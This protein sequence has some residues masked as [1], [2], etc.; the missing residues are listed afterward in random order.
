MRLLLLSV[1]SLA[2]LSAAQAPL[3]PQT[4]TFNSNFALTAAQIS[5]AGLSS[6]AAANVAIAARFERSNW[7]PSGSVFAD[8][9]YLNLP[10]NAATAPAGSVLKVEAFTDTT[11]Y[12]IA[13]TL[14]LSRI[15]YQ[16]RQLN[17]SLAPVSAYILWPYHPRRSLAA[18]LNGSIPLVSWGHGS[19]GSVPECGPSHIRNLWNQFSAPYELALAGYAVVATDYA[20][21]GV[22]WFPRNDSDGLYGVNITHQF[23]ASAAA[24]N[25]VLYA[26]QAAHAAF[27]DLLTRDFVVVGH[28]QGGGAAWAAAER[29]L[30]AQVPGYLGA[31][32]AAPLTNALEVIQANPGQ[33]LGFILSARGIVAAFPPGQ[34]ALSDILTTDG[35]AIMRLLEQVQGCSS[36][37]GTLLDGIFSADP[38]RQLLNPQLLSSSLVQRYQNLTGAGGKDFSGPMLVVQGDADP[39]VP[40]PVT[41]HTVN[42]T[43]ASYPQRSLHYVRAQSVGHI[44]VMYATRQIW[45]DWIEDRFAGVT[46]SSGCSYEYIGGNAPRP[47]AQYQGDLNYFLEYS[48]SPYQVA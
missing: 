5:A 20:G 19:V 24:G 38:T 36:V 6:V 35:I 11:G 26:A 46:P 31:V 2:A 32:A 29:Q 37:F 40:E 14:A 47:L 23:G 4:D 7:A 17:G 25:D 15:I 30:T 10:A 13:P 44:P 18:R 39:A 48:L 21:L 22:P 16:S 34:V 1:A 45:L 8:P 33:A 42:L 3:S 43:C 27:P 41:T 12:T 28:S 9:F